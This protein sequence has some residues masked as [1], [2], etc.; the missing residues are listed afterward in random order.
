MKHFELIVQDLGKHFNRR[1]IFRGLTFSL[2]L[3]DSLAITGKNGSGKSTLSRILAGVLSPS[4]GFVQY[5]SEGSAIQEER[6]KDAVGFVS[7][8]LNLYDEFTATENLFLLSMIRTNQNSL[9]TRVDDVL[10]RVGLWERRNDQVGIYSSG[11]KQRLKYA[12][13]L[14]HTP[15]MLI[16]D[17][18]TS[19]LD[20]DGVKLVKDIVRAQKKIGILVIATNDSREVRWCEKKIVLNVGL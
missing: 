15:P 5:S 12:F 19:N 20:N 3:G 16:L 1:S 6:M 4:S 14:L 9:E 8:Y 10:R 11:M 18:P 2:A 7:P 17:E 13:A